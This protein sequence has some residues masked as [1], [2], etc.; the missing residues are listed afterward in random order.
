MGLLVSLPATVAIFV[1]A[2]RARANWYWCWHAGVGTGTAGPGLT[3]VSKDTSCS[4][5]SPH[6]SGK[7][8]EPFPT[9]RKL[10]RVPSDL[11]P[12]CPFC[13]TLPPA[14]GRSYPKCGPPHV[15]HPSFG[16]PFPSARVL[17]LARCLAIGLSGAAAFLRSCILSF[18]FLPSFLL[19][20]LH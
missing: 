2:L 16:P 7:P 11:I 19:L 4:S 10:P 17:C 5:S 12:G 9:V 1:L 3:S 18:P 6:A 14:C 13:P 20:L 8:H 15:Q